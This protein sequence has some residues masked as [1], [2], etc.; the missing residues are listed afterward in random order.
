MF[1]TAPFCFYVGT[2]S[3]PKK[4]KARNLATP[5]RE[6]RAKSSYTWKIGT[7]KLSE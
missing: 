1:L 7:E 3:T 6:R 4:Q 2:D 5:A